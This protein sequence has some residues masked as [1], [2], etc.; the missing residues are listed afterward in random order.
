M[1]FAKEKEDSTLKPYNFWSETRRE[2]GNKECSCG[3]KM[4]VIQL[5]DCLLYACEHCPYTLP[6][7]DKDYAEAKNRKPIYSERVSIKRKP[8][9][10]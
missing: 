10:R 9:E 1:W 7:T 8:C 4:G 3:H 5:G 6:V 2:F